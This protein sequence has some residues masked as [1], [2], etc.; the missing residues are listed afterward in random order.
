M[1]LSHNSLE[2]FLEQEGRE[3]K[4]GGEGGGRETGAAQP[5]T[6]PGLSHV[7]GGFGGPAMGGQL[8][9]SPE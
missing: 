9:S 4:E 7:L 2:H 3:E 1:L 6:L 5:W 8:L